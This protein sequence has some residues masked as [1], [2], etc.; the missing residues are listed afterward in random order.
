MSLKSNSIDALYNGI[1]QQPA[2]MRLPSQC[3]LQINGYGSVAD[4]LSK[5]PPTEHLATLSDTAF[6]SAFIHIINRD[7]TERYAVVITDEVVTVYDLSDGS[8]QTVVLDSTIAWPADTAVVVDELV[9]P[10]TA[11]KMLFRCTTAG[12]TGATEPTWDT[13]AGNT[14]NDNTAVWTAIAN[15]MAIPDGALASESFEM[16]TVADYSFIVNKTKTVEWR[17]TGSAEPHGY[18]NWF[19]PDNWTAAAD[20]TR[21]YVPTAGTDQQSVQTLED[22]PADDDPS[23]P[24]ENDFY[25]IQS[26]PDG[27]FNKYYVIYIGGVWQE[28]HARNISQTLDE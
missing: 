15:Y 21:Y 17:Y 27:G 25:T 4:G 28:T 6:G 20:E 9:R 7:A 18:G 24:S 8:E 3:E 5:R 11:N 23:P 12:T 16:V 10:T 1:S 2:N 13:G 26:D 19:F 22:L 14:T